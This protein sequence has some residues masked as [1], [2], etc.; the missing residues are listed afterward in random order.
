[1]FL[2]LQ[3]HYQMQLCKPMLNLSGNKYGQ[4]LTLCPQHLATLRDDV[5]Q[6]VSRLIDAR[7]KR[8]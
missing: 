2:P 5:E 7:R 6:A 8:K 1:M 4:N 3:K